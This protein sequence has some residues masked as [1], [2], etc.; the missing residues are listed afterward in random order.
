MK[1]LTTKEIAERYGVKLITA[2]KWVQRG[3]FPNK[4]MYGRD[5][6]I[7]ESDLLKF[8]KPKAGRPRKVT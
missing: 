3:L 5:W 7:P 6:L 1:L 2:Q 4:H 8:K